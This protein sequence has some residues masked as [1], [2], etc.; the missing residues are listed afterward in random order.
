MRRSFLPLVFVFSALFFSCDGIFS[1]EES[2]S[3]ETTVD[4]SKVVTSASFAEA[5]VTLS[6]GEVRHVVFNVSPSTAVASAEVT[7]AFSDPDNQVA[8][9]SGQSSNGLILTGLKA[10]NAVLV[11][12]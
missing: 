8:S 4:T 1:D 7:Y 12:K 5:S 2:E 9:L 6:V 10:G 3:E 11:A